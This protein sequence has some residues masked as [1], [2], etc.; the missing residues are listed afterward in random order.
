MNLAPFE[1][2]PFC[3]LAPFAFCTAFCTA[4][5]HMRQPPYSIEEMKVMLCGKSMRLCK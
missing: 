3:L 5:I 1:P 4:V 2:G